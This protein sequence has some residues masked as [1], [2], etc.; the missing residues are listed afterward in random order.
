M[1][2]F[3]GNRCPPP[4]FW[5]SAV[6]AAALLALP[7]G[8]SKKDPSGSGANSKNGGAPNPV[9]KSDAASSPIAQ[10]LG[11]PDNRA[12]TKANWAKIKWD[13]T[14]PGAEAILGRGTQLDNTQAFAEMGVQ[15]DDSYTRMK[16]ESPYDGAQWLTW[17][18][19]KH[20]HDKILIG[21]EDEKPSSASKS[22]ETLFVTRNGDSLE[23][24]GK[25]GDDITYHYKRNE[26]DKL[27]TLRE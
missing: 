15:Y 26:A 7:L 17:F 9:A 16:L 4:L 10:P 21:F 8:C 5:V 11:I 3:R 6:F 2:C 12:A 20:G 13:T 22:E 18:V 1:M 23:M 25:F 27:I 14:L 24:D 19:W